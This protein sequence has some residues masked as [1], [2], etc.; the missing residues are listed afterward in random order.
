METKLQDNSINTDALRGALN[1]VL[2]LPSGI[3]LGAVSSGVCDS[4]F[5]MNVW[6]TRLIFTTAA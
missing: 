2:L 3:G 4:L 6:W 1:H 5:C